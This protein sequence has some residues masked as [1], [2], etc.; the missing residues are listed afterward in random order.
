MCRIS[1]ILECS[2]S[3]HYW[4]VFPSSCDYSG[5]KLSIT[6]SMVFLGKQ[7]W[8][9]FERFPHFQAKPNVKSVHM[10]PYVMQLFYVF[11]VIFSD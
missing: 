4:G 6:V 10:F 5:N 1:A 11:A 8:Q 9:C 7:A 3:H 2:T